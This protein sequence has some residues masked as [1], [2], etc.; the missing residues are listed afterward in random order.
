M[1]VHW[2]QACRVTD[3]PAAGVAGPTYSAPITALPGALPADVD[4]VEVLVQAQVVVD[5]ALLF[6]SP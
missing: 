6:L 2:H 5:L 3:R 4:L 1:H